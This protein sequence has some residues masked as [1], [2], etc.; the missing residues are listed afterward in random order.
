[1]GRDNLNAYFFKKKK[2]KVPRG[3]AYHVIKATESRRM[4]NNPNH[5]ETRGRK[6]K[7]SERDLCVAEM[8]LWRCG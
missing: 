7:L 6:S 1:M 5:V 2:K 8:I 4:H 3:S